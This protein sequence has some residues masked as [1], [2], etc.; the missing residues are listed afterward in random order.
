MC[1]EVIKMVF[2]FLARIHLHKELLSPISLATGDVVDDKAECG[3]QV[4]YKQE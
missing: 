3:C 2:K 4:Y 1:H